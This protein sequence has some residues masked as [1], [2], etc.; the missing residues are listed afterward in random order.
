MTLREAR[1]G[2]GWTQEVLAGKSGVDQA[3][4]SGIERGR[5]KSPTFDTVTKLA[6]ALQID[7]RQLRFGVEVAA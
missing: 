7:P 1:R 5:V 3:T 4:I 6:A 2:R